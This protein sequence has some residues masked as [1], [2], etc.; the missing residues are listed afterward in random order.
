MTSED[1]KVG[2][3]AIVR[4]FEHWQVSGE[5]ACRILALP[6]AT[7]RRWQTGEVGE[8][9]PDQVTRLSV[10]LGIHVGLQ[11]LYVDRQRG[12]G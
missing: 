4:L 10:L 3:G 1:A 9:S 11:H 6:V 12:Y 2:A 5:Q 7:W 8:V